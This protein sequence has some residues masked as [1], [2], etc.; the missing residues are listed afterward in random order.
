L[1]T[2]IGLILVNIGLASWYSP[3]GYNAWGPRL[4]LPFLGS[5]AILAIYLTANETI[6]YLKK[7]GINRGLFVILIIIAISSLPNIA[8][9]LDGD[10]FFTKMFAKTNIE[11]N[12]DI[13]NFTIQSAPISQ[14]MDASIEAYSKNIIIPSTIKNSL[15]Y[16][17][18]IFIW[19]ISLFYI[20]RQIILTS[21]EKNEIINQ[22][23]NKSNYHIISINIKIKQRLINISL[24]KKY[25]FIFIAILVIIGGALLTK[26]HRESCSICFD[27]WHKNRLGEA[28]AEYQ[29]VAPQEN[30]VNGLDNFPANL[31]LA[32]INIKLTES[33]LMEAV[34]ISAIDHQGNDLGNWVTRPI[35]YLWGI[36]IIDNANPE[37][38]KN[39]GS[40]K[41]NLKLPI[42]PELS[43]LIPDNGN[44]SKKPKLYIQIYYFGG[45][46]ISTIAFYKP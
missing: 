9:R 27:L 10:V 20:C 35:N 39:S 31:P 32:K 43:L 4:S 25:A 37:L 36:G 26:T 42:G 33:E 16:W 22:Y 19:L 34:S 44:L 18:I 6:I 41:E 3:F 5:I 28:I 24:T 8:V 11:I 29:L 30:L 40:R 2:L 46:R 17:P 1:F 21:N 14:Y 7:L 45:K 13:Q 12:S 38:L 15:T 23:T